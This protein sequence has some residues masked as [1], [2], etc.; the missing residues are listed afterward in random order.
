VIAF[1]SSPDQFVEV[2]L[3]LQHQFKPASMVVDESE[4]RRFPE[5]ALNALDYVAGAN[6]TIVSILHTFL[7]ASS[8]VVQDLVRHCL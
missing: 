3:Q 8:P 5:D 6:C 2:N 7:T 4:L 1:L